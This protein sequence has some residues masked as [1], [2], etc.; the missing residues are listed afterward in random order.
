MDPLIGVALYI[1]LWWIAFFAVLPI[2]VRNLEEA[3]E[4]TDAGIERGA[5]HR[6]RLWMKALWAAGV[7]AAAW[8]IV[9]GAVRM[10]LF[11]IRRP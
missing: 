5:P 2:G 3:G 4:E 7:A 9:Y 6:P 1:I 8:L 11:A 10:D